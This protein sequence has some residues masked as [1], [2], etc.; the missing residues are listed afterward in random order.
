MTI[1]IGAISADEDH[2]DDGRDDEA[3]RRRR[4]LRVGARNSAKIRPNNLGASS[5][6]MVRANRSSDALGVEPRPGGEAARIRA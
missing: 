1:M 2:F 6:A 5:T 3:E 4:G